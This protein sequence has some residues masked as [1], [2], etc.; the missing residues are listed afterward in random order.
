MRTVC[1][2][3]KSAEDYLEAI[4]ILGQ[5]QTAV[6]SVDIVRFLEHSKSSVSA[7]VNS[8]QD[9]GFLTME[10]GG[11]LHLTKIGCQEAQ[12]VYAKHCVIQ[13]LLE[14]CGVPP[15]TAE[16]DACR[17]EHMLSADSFEK[18]QEFYNRYQAVIQKEKIHRD[19]SLY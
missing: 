17:I 5:K 7:A 3:K 18:V 8:L 14:Y 16:R 9:D 4:Y 19:A 13:D 12:R 15:E 10:Q 2:I 1:E 11:A 6:H